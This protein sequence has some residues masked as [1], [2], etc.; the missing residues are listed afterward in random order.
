MNY[1]FSFY[2][3]ILYCYKHKMEGKINRFVQTSTTHRGKSALMSSIELHIESRPA[4][5]GLRAL[6]L[7]AYPAAIHMMHVWRRQ[8]LRCS[9]H[10][11][12]AQVRLP[13]AQT[14]TQPVCLCGG[15]STQRDHLASG[16]CTCSQFESARF[17]CHHTSSVCQWLQAG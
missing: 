9:T 3:F 10:Q 11:A 12:L 16:R 13:H 4:V 8:K 15:V 1:N 17:G 2:I 14:A 7:T 5:L 6:S